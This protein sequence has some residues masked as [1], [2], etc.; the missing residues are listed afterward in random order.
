MFALVLKKDSEWQPAIQKASILSVK[1]DRIG[2]TGLCLIYRLILR[3][4]KLEY[5]HKKI[6]HFSHIKMKMLRFH[7]VWQTTLKNDARFIKIRGEA[8][9]TG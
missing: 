4:H 5:S 7:K 1:V 8:A 9:G 2:L 3:L 6:P